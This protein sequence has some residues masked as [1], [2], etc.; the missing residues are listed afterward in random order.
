ME[1]Y[2]LEQTEGN[3]YREVKEKY[4]DNVVIF[5]SILRGG[6]FYIETFRLLCAHSIHVP[7]QQV[8]L[9][10]THSSPPLPESVS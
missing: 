6:K 1:L 10:S 5:L 2:G 8:P 9:A 3:V 7:P 4:T